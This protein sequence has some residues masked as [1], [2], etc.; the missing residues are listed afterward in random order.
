MDNIFTYI[1]YGGAGIA[2][3]GLVGLGASLY[4]GIK[5]KKDAPAPEEAKARMRVLIALNTASLGISF[6]GLA[7][8]AVGVLVT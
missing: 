7:L 1:V 4:L 3:L 8:A 2:A 6:F 5:L